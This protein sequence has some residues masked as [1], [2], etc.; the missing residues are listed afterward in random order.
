MVSPGGAAEVAVVTWSWSPAGRTLSSIVEGA[1]AAG[2]DPPTGLRITPSSSGHAF[3]GPSVPR[4]HLTLPK[5]FMVLS[6]TT[7]PPSVGHHQQLSRVQAQHCCCQRLI[8]CACQV[9]PF[10]DWISGLAS[11]VPLSLRWPRGLFI[12]VLCLRGSRQKMVNLSQPTSD[13]TVPL[14]ATRERKN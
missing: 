4:L 11:F 10:F 6:E 3:K 8:G 14:S 2:E 13:L 1:E 5:C 12:K 9:C 7:R